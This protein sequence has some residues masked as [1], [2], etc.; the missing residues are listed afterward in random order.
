MTEIYLLWK[1]FRNIVNHFGDNTVVEL[2]EMI[3][4]E[5]WLTWMLG[6]IQR[7]S[8]ILAGYL[9][10]YDA[11]LYTLVWQAYHY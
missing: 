2:V 1:S 7:C 10:W 9:Q 3:A 5:W 8:L 4:V 11:E 6:D